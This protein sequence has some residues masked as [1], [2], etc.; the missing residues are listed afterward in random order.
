MSPADYLQML[1]T[2]SC[3]NPPNTDACGN[4][5]SVPGQIEKTAGIE[6]WPNPGSGNFTLRLPYFTEG[7]TRLSLVDVSGRSR[8]LEAFAYGGI[9]EL[10][11]RNEGLAP[12]VYALRAELA[13]K[14]YLAKL[15]IER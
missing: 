8:N 12:G 5:L 2:V 15:I 4:V 13:G 6:V 1:N 10:D 3:S 14:I 11:L 7:K 9:L